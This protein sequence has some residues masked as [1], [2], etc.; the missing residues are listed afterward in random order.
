MCIRDRD[1]IIYHTIALS[2]INLVGPKTAKLLISYAGGVN[3][4]FQLSKKDL[5]KI[6]GIGT[7]LVEN[8]LSEDHF[9][10]ADKEIKF[11]EKNDIKALSYLDPEYPQ[12]CLHFEDAPLLLF[13]KG[14]ADLNYG[15]TVSIVGTRKPTQYVRSNCEKLIDGLT[16]YSPLIISG[17]AYGIDSTAHRKSVESGIP[18]VAVSYTHLTLPTTP[19]V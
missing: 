16:D 9:D 18:N 4:V 5:M 7:K 11:L 10:A 3:E 14:N 6:P 1:D 19:Y 13:Y 12:R 8:I 15:R 2:K 17:L